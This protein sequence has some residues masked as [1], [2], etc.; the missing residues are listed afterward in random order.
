MKNMMKEYLGENYTENNHL[1][2]FCLYWIKASEGSGDE[3]R[4]NNDLDCLYFDGDLRADTLI[5]TWTPIKW[6][7]D[8]LNQDTGKRF[9]K[10]YR[11][12]N[13]PLRDLKLLADDRDAYLPERHELTLLLDRL[14]ELAELRCNYILLPDR[15]M[16]CDRYCIRRGGEKLWLYDSVPATLFHAFNTD[17]LGGYFADTDPK[18]WI[19]REHLDVAFK[20]GIVDV[21]HIIPMICNTKPEE[22]YW[23]IE[24]EDIRQALIY[25]IKL[26]ERRMECVC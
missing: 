7:A 25:M 26:L 19:V 18:E 5:S 23:L 17:T 13:D 20:D 21:K 22:P 4:K 8:Y 3:W 12:T 6:V 2:N 14:L 16:N 11:D 15:R 1:K 9:Y 10:K 24:E